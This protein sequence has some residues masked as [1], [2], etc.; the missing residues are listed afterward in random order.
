M[1]VL[2]GIG[3]SGSG[4]AYHSADISGDWRVDELE[5]LRVIQLFNVGEYQCLPESEDGYG[6]GFADRS[7]PLHDSDF[8]QP[9]WDISL[10]ELLRLVQLH[11]SGAYHVKSG[12]EDD[13]AMGP[14][15]LGV[16]IN[17]IHY[18]PVNKTQALEFIELYN[19]GSQVEDLSGWYF[20]DGITF[21]FP[22]GTA[23]NPG[24][25]LVIAENPSVLSSLM[26]AASL[27][28]WEG[29]L[30]NDGETVTLR[31]SFGDKVDEVDYG[32]DF[33]WPT[34]A[35]GLGGSMELIHPGFDND[36]GGHWRTSGY[37]TSTSGA[38][39]WL[40]AQDPNWHYRKGQ[41]EA[42][43]PSSAWRTSDFSEDS[44]WLVGATPVGYGDEDDLS[45][46]ED[47][48]N[49]YSTVFLR[50]TFEIDAGAVPEMLTVSTYVDDGVIIWVNGVE[51]VR[52][53]VAA[54]EPAFNSL[55]QTSVQEAQWTEHVLDDTSFLVEGTNTI[56]V[57]AFNNPLN[58]SD[59][60]VDV[61]LESTQGAPGREPTPGGI[62]TV[63]ATN[64]PP[65]MRQLT[66]YPQQPRTDEDVTVSIKVSDAEGVSAVSLAYQIVA[67]GDYINLED[68]RYETQWTTLSMNDA[69]MD[70]DEVAYDDIYTVVIPGQMHQHRHLYRYRILAEDLTDA[71]SVAPYDD[72]LQPNFA[73][74]AYDDVPDWTGSARPGVAPDVTYS[75]ELLQS[76]ATY[77]LITTHRAHVDSQ[78][79]PD[80]NAGEYRGSEYPWLGTF[81][82]D[83]EVYDHIRFRPRGG[84]WRF[85]MGKNMWKFNFNKGHRFEG[86]DD[87]GQK[88]DTKQDKLNFSA[89]IQQG[90]TNLRG[91]Q[92]LLESVTFGMFNLAGIEG[93]QTNFAHFRLI[94][95]AV[96]TGNTQYDGDFQGM[97][98]V[99][100]QM[101]GQF[102]DEHDLPDG[103]LYKMEN[104]TGELNNQG[105]TQPVNKSDL[106][107]FLSAYTSQTQS[108][109]WWRNNV[110][111]ERYYNY[112]AIVDCTR[113]YDI[114]W[115]KNYFYFNNPETGKW[116]VH[117]WDV[118]I[119]WKD[120]VWGDDNEPF[121]QPVLVE[122]PVFYQEYA[123]RLREVRDLLYNPEQIGMLIDEMA[124]IIY[125]PGALSWVDAD[126]AMWDY[127]PI[128]ISSYVAEWQS[129]QGKFYNI[130]P[131][132]DFAGM[133]QYMKNYSTNRMTW[134]DSTF[135]QDENNIP[136]TPVIRYTGTQGYPK[137]AL[138]FTTSN[139]ASPVSSFGALKW[140]I[141]EV[142]NPFAPDF[143]RNQRR[144]YEITPVWESEEITT[145]DAAMTIPDGDLKPG[146]TY[147]VRARMKDSQGRWSH[148]STALQF[149]SGTASDV[150][151]LALR[152]TEI[153]YRPAA[154]SD[155]EIAAGF[156]DAGD[157]E[158]I[159]LHNAG[160]SVLDLGG[161][162][163]TNGVLFDFSTG[164]VASLAPGDYV[165]V[166]KNIAAFEMRY[167]TG[168]PV[169]GEF[170]G[171]LN[172]GGESIRMA[173]GDGLSIQDFDYG[174][175]HSL[176]DGGGFSLTIVDSAS[177]VLASWGDEG[178][179]RASSALHGSPG[180]T[181][182][183]LAPL[184]GT[185]V[186][187]EILAHS[188]AEAPDWIELFNSTDAAVDV[189]GWYL[190]DSGENR[191]KYEIATDMVIPANG[192]VVFYEDESFGNADEADTLFALSENGETVYLSSAING[193][194]TGYSDEEGFGASA[195][196]VAF[197]R[198]YKASTDTYN[199]VAMSENTP[200]AENGAPRVGPIVI[201]EIMYHPLGANSEYIELYNISA[202]SVSL[203]DAVTGARWKMSDG[204]DL[205]FPAESTLESGQFM[206]IVKDAILFS[207][208][209]P[210]V[211]EGT[212]ILEW[213]IGSLSNGGERI[214]L[215]M[216]GDV[217]G[218]GE[219]Q[220]IR[221]D[222]VNYD[223]AFPWPI[224][225][226][227]TGTALKRLDFYSY[228]NDV[229][230][231]TAAPASPGE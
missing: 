180:V 165:L 60:S 109:G 61:Q 146:K 138:S 33:P 106:N 96:E 121:K 30:S 177:S 71:A 21:E 66:Q 28:P 190:S 51:I 97:Y 229:S 85:A 17:E 163:F 47:M 168:L 22:S 36:L 175:W 183:S 63:Y 112:R 117:P 77:Q 2:A 195:T 18:E 82:Y 115:G 198:H 219:R 8:R 43:T 166:V 114:A 133:I 58:S 74:F 13:F 127:N 102:L 131:T 206:L 231:W 59:L 129:G 73:Y 78:H 34:G 176:T 144:H 160:N 162:V 214:D 101:D 199:F 155:A 200:G 178:A 169:A 120:D 16:V 137:N 6:P 130:A 154:P 9:T 53:N 205:I 170:T 139:F 5:L 29:S 42:S 10:S 27:G 142:T 124:S 54:G 225:P 1:I 226:D 187:N 23:M 100:E 164:A 140:R 119:S 213:R 194:L 186:L 201:S 68:P 84:V 143:D 122:K 70:G 189:G 90:G 50:N 192:Y 158:F 41:S 25:Y 184:P 136:D 171:S 147:R 118:D 32:T 40:S 93:P 188:H 46:L 212:A 75:S 98:L 215:S 145:F 220:Y 62:N 216:P 179:W 87:Y 116:Q 191:M 210:D 65:V 45:V 126:R 111:L 49:N 149:V 224:S 57:Q 125:T 182:E 14:S 99:I 11:N 3:C 132:K 72:D 174:N 228:G 222:R 52:Q 203:E 185:I 81:V 202:N 135:L 56:A 15:L 104:G 113:H 209:Y 134:L 83:G 211:P 94:R 55:A 89:I 227:G 37:R 110:D 67:P 221:V 64:A 193:T 91:E 7:C 159:E 38:A 35:Q 88:Y 4:W 218:L 207:M 31:D 208:A 167:G 230:N 26:G 103:N 197:G 79:I 223:D 24:D 150:P 44:S 157:F 196:G 151:S 181:D 204:I 48:R 161:V 92:G 76:I 108:E 20:S 95:S 172:N 153:M 12:N 152:V 19:A 39:V 69:G 107:A 141:A 86:R 123:N 217:N 128:M 156:D 173:D 80:S 105:A 148:W